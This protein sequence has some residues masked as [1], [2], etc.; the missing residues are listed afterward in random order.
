MSKAS[1]IQTN[2]TAGEL[3]PRL[4]GRTDISKYANGCQTLK[5]M[6]VQPH[7]GVTRRGGTKYIAEVKTSS[8]RVELVPFEF[9]TTQ[10]YVLEFGDQYIRFYMDQGQI[11]SGGSPYEIATTYLEAELA[12]LQFAQSADTMYIVH[13]DHAPAKLTRTGHTAWT[14]TTISFTATPAAWGAGNYPQTVAFYEQ[15]L[16]LAA[17]PNEPQTLWFSKSD[18]Y[19]NLT[20]GTADDDAMDYTIATDQVNAIQWLSPGKILVAGT[21]GGEFSVS[22][23]SLDEALTPTNIRIIRQSTYGSMKT[24]PIRISNFVLFV[25]RAKRKLRRFEFRFEDDAYD[26]PDMTLLAEHITL[27]GIT[28]PAYQQDHDSV[29]WLVR[30]DGALIGFTHQKDQEVFAWHRHIVGGQSDA[31]GT[32]SKVESI[33]TIPSTTAEDG[34]ELWMV[35]NREIDGSTVRYVEVLQP[36]LRD[37]E[38]LDEAF[39]LDSG[40]SL[41]NPIDITGATQANPVV[42]T[43]PS[44]GLSNGDAAKIRDIVGMTELNGRSYTAANVTTDT[45]ELTGVDGTTY[46]TYVSGGTIREEVTAVSG[47]NHLEG[48]TVSILADGASHPNKTVASGAITLDRAA[49]IIHVGYGFESDVETLRP[50]VG[51]PAGTAQGRIKRISEV[52]I[53]FYR[54]LGAKVG[55]HNRATDEHVLDIIPFRTSADEMDAPPALFSG[56]KELPFPRGY[57]TANRIFIRQDQPL[58]MTVSSVMMEVRTNNV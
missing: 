50:D 11:E 44:H 21:V 39:F 29:V 49:S 33:A 27:Q 25:Q 43:A 57:D 3:S 31:A 8:K 24:M 37:T 35:V 23:S 53:R 4:E 7:G 48:E 6:V 45:L 12:E 54:T 55:F 14:L 13:K 51:N 1:Y 19:E 2:F 42:I 16:V 17:T 10:A 36:G 15:R 58:P 56:D 28:R 30:A 22:A 32:Q 5:N 41:D 52:V 20:I 34:D 9:S 46:S 38:G 26:A 18:D 47:L 40:L